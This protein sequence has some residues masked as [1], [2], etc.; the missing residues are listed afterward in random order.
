[1]R[2]KYGTAIVAIFVLLAAAIAC[3]PTATQTE[4]APVEAPAEDGIAREQENGPEEGQGGRRRL[5]ADAED[6]EED[7]L[8][9]GEEGRPE[10]EAEG[11]ILG[12]VG[13]W[14]GFQAIQ[15]HVGEE[16]AEEGAVH[17]M[18]SGVEPLEARTEEALDAEREKQ[19]KQQRLRMF[20][21]RLQQGLK[22]LELNHRDLTIALQGMG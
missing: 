19:R 4:V 17:Q 10:Q 18:V 14:V 1:M 9:Q 6:G 7:P 13:E 8:D 21:C 12:I 3:G 11:R 5:L 15:R 16:I 22:L 20:A 2:T